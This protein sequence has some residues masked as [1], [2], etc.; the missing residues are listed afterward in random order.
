M[1]SGSRLTDGPPFPTPWTCG[2]TE[3]KTGVG[4]PSSVVVMPSSLTSAHQKCGQSQLA[5]RTITLMVNDV[6]FRC[7]SRHSASPVMGLD[8][9]LVSRFPVGT[10]HEPPPTA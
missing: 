4:T 6:V 3:T 8:S 9:V 2:R 5:P 1:T 10:F 7:D